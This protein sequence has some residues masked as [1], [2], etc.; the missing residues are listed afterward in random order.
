MWNKDVFLF[1]EDARLQRAQGEAVTPTAAAATLFSCSSMT[2][3][4]SERNH[5]DRSHGDS[6]RAHPCLA[7]SA[8][9]TQ[10][11]VSGFP[12]SPSPQSLFA[13]NFISPRHT[14]GCLS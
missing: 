2:F 4:I 5:A 14:P 12:G 9:Q 1:L 3:H 7:Y 13:F 6:P 11:E 10:V 8:P